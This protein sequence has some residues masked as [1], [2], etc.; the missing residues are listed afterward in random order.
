M[1]S[2]NESDSEHMFT[3][4]WEDICDDSQS[5]PSINR[6]YACY[7]IHDHIKRGQSEWKGALLSTQNMGKG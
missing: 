2:G 1:S 5:D 6:R 3:D 4:M 7:K